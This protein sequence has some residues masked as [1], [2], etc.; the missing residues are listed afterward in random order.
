MQM[1]RITR[2]MVG[3][4]HCGVLSFARVPSNTFLSI[5]RFM[6]VVLP[7]E[8]GGTPNPRCLAYARFLSCWGRKLQPRSGC[9]DTFALN[10]RSYFAVNLRCGAFWPNAQRARRRELFLERVL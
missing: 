7:H 2:R 5:G 8:R 6:L 4:L 10:L 9:D 3:S 1:S